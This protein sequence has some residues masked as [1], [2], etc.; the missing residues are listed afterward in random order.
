M[1]RQKLLRPLQ[2]LVNQVRTYKHNS[3]PKIWKEDGVKYGLVTYYPRHKNHVDPPITPTKLFLI[4][5]VK[6]Y[7]GIPYWEKQILKNINLHGEKNTKHYAVVKNTPEMCSMLWKIKHLIKVTPLNAPDKLPEPESVSTYL[8]EN[9]D[10]LIF[11]KVDKSRYEATI[12]FKNDPKRMDGETLAEVLRD[13]W[14][15]PME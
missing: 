15:N 8:H 12:A 9:G 14:V 3:T 6:Q 2:C 13:K 5:R 11:P 4:E 10:L 1:S 7:K